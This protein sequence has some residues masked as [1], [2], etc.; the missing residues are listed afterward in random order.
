[1]SSLED[2]SQNA[3]QH[4]TEDTTPNRR[5]TW[6]G[7]S[8]LLVLT[9]A[10]Y[11][12]PSIFWRGDAL[13]GIDYFQLHAWRIAFAR[14]ALFG[15]GHFLP[16]WYPHE[17]L[18]TPFSANLQSFPWVPVRLVLLLFEPRL[19]YAIGVAL[20][21]GL[22]AI[23]TYLYCRRAGLSDVGA[24]AAGWTFACAGF[25]SSR[26]MAGHLP[27][28]EAYPA[29]PLLLWLADRAI[30]QERAKY[31]GRDL[32]V[33]AVA[34]A[35]VAVAGHP[36]V[37]AYSLASAVLYVVLRGR[38]WLRLKACAAM[39]LGLGATLFAWWPMLLLVQRSTR[40]LPLAPAANDLAMPY[41]RL[42]ALVRPGIDGWPPEVNGLGEKNPFHGYPSTAY[43]W[44]SSSYMGL[45]PLAVILFLFFRILM[46]RRL[47]G[48]PWQFLAVLG[49]GALLFSLP[50]AE[51]LRRMTP[52]TFLRSPAR[53]LYLSTFAASVALGFGVNAFL[54]CNLFTLR[55]RQALV[56]FC[57]LGH[58]LDLG[59]FARTFVQTTDWPEQEPQPFEQILARDV[60]DGRIAADDISYRGHFDDAGAFD[61]ILLANPY[62]ALLGL[63]GSPRDLNEQHLD[64]TLF[65]IPALQAAGVKFVITL[66]KRPDLEVVSSSA[67]DHLYRVPNPAPRAAF[68]AEEAADFMPPDKILDTFIANPRRDRLLLPSNAGALPHGDPAPAA[69]TV[70]YFRP[71]SDE[72]RLET[73]ASQPGYASVL[74][75]YDPGWAA[76][77]DGAPAVV[78]LANGFTMAVPVSPGKHSIR[79]LYHTPGR[80]AGGALSIISIFLLGCLWLSGNV[81]TV[82]ATGK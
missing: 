69:A 37:P 19:H 71:S 54:N 58:A 66:D 55:A 68:F 22:S 17:L 53:L 77:V 62:R 67:D 35:C 72:I 10:V 74:E 47:P 63:N 73:E 57:L 44:D 45:L 51:P 40:V 80:A 42:L 81:T 7:V 14:N 82:A 8:L 32:G 64:A 56:G 13:L 31:H 59:G 15:E 27:L 76:D 33:L 3:V 70:N 41:R 39:A 43:F 11:F 61:S 25:F 2:S 38:G 50:L 28:I 12:R 6:V 79:L 60:K 65:K 16:A 75:S 46:K 18:G 29:L 36:Q 78:V 49:A 4:P 24:I 23:F 34:S 30:D 20:A 5:R 48:W 1:M 21:A 52:G 9:E 26:V